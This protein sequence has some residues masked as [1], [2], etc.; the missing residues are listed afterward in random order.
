MT[1]DKAYVAELWQDGVMVAKVDAPTAREANDE[2]S[3]YAFVYAQDGPVK[4]V[5]KWARKNK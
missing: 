1:K 4:V 5:R 3:H 2:I